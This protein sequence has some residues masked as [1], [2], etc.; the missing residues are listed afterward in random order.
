MFIKIQSFLFVYSKIILLPIENITKNYSHN[1][2]NLKEYNKKKSP[3]QHCK[4]LILIN[5]QIN[6][7]GPYI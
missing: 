1:N 6:L 7:K 4:L 3:C 5:T 2:L